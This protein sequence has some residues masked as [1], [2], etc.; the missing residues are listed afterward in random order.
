M[1]ASLGSGAVIGPLAFAAGVWIVGTITGHNWSLDVYLIAAVLG[2]GIG[3]GLVTYVSLAWQP[4]D[5]DVAA[6]L[7]GR[8]GRADAPLEGAEAVDEGR[9]PHPA[10]GI[11]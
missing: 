9:A 5:D 11:R 7:R 10:G 6:G 2:I 8:R 1:L 3:M 4:D